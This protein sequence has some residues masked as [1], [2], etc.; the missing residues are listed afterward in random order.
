[1]LLVICW[2]L[3]FP[4]V[5]L[6]ERA[7]GSVVSATPAVAVEEVDPNK[8]ASELNHHLA[9][10]AL[11]AIAL[12]VF[13]GE[14]SGKMRFCRWIWP[15]LFIATGLFLAAWSDAEI[16]PRGDLSWTWLIHHDFEARQH[17]VFAL[18]LLL[19]GIVEYLRAG[20]RLPRFWRIWAFPL[21]AV[22][23][24]LLLLFHDH[25]Q[26]SG[27]SSAEAQAYK[28]SWLQSANPAPQP[29]S[30]ASTAE[31][32]HQHHHMAEPNMA[33][34]TTGSSA[35]TTMGAADPHEGMQMSGGAEHHHHHMTASQMKVEGEHMWFLVVG[36]GIALFKLLRDSEIWKRPFVPFLWPSL[37]GV[38]GLLLIV[39]TE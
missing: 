23:G 12:L 2:Q 14:S 32:E 25:T 13:L 27:A 38:L 10:Y 18:V 24:A 39:Y 16:W 29:E 17:K 37:M 35:T 36:I 33:E 4:R 22:F 5:L 8:A 19:I 9:G 30:A 15:L 6:S 31:G 28:V 11:V 34:P 7:T 1:M 20:N 21:L 3:I 26:A